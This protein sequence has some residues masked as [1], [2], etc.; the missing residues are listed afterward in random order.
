MSIRVKIKLDRSALVGMSLGQVPA[1]AEGELG[2]EPG[3]PDLILV[4]RPGL[5]DLLCTKEGRPMAVVSRSEKEA[6]KP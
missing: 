4:K 2:G 1:S 3:Y 6:K 5:C